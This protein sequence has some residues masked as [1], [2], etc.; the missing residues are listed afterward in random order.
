MRYL[1]RPEDTRRV[2]M[3]PAEQWSARGTTPIQPAFANPGPQSRARTAEVQLREE[4]RELSSTMRVRPASASGQTK[5]APEIEEYFEAVVEEIASDAIC[6]RTRSSGGEEAIAWLRTEHITAEER[7]YIALGA[8]ARI[9]ILV[10]SVP[11]RERKTEVRFLRPSQWYRPT[12]TEADPVVDLL[13]QRMNEALA[14][15]R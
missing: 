3:S 2:P 11:R 1:S 5:H 15:R 10:T 12:A 13:V 6:L 7:K 4:N 14:P 8:P 9:T